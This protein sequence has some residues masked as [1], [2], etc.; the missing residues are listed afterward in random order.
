MKR[1][2]ETGRRIA[3]AQQ[4]MLTANLIY[5]QVQGEWGG[6]YSVSNIHVKRR[7]GQLMEMRGIVRPILLFPSPLHQY[8]PCFLQ[9]IKRD[10]T[11]VIST[12]T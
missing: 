11:S 5:M 12:S 2:N 7:P 4:E 1:D 8:Q 10:I 6:A 9:G 3:M